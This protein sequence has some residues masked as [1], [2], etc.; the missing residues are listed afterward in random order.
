MMQIAAT[1]MSV[2]LASTASAADPMMK[3]VARNL[4]LNPTARNS[5]KIKRAAPL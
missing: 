3:L 4:I 2:L 1:V 5:L